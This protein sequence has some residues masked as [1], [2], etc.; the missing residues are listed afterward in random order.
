M[1]DSC[2]LCSFS[3]PAI[4][5][6]LFAVREAEAVGQQLEHAG[7]EHP[8]GKI[9]RLGGIQGDVL[10]VDK[11]G[12]ELPA[13]AAGRGEAI[14]LLG[15]HRTGHKVALAFAANEKLRILGYFSELSI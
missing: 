11:L 9:A 5:P 1:D 3:L 12:E 2:Q 15:H 10:A 4:Y 8:Q 7:A 14:V 13:D 6:I